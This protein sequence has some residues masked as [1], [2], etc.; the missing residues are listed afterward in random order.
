MFPNIPSLLYFSTLVCL[1][2][3][4]EGEGREGTQAK[5]DSQPQGALLY[6]DSHSKRC[7]QSGWSQ[8]GSRNCSWGE[9]SSS[10]ACAGSWAY[11][12]WWCPCPVGTEEHS[13]SSPSPPRPTLHQALLPLLPSV[14]SPPSVFPKSLPPFIY[15][16]IQELSG[17]PFPHLWSGWIGIT[18]PW[19]YIPV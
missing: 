2:W 14:F 3:A 11:A 7:L 8:T 12:T 5:R 13:S 4:G 6:L 19:K 17:P 9:C 16:P 18:K 15:I 1:S 10:W